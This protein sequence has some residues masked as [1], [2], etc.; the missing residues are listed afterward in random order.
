[1]TQD[2][3]DDAHRHVLAAHLG[4]EP[5]EDELATTVAGLRQRLQEARSADTFDVGEIGEAVVRWGHSPAGSCSWMQRGGCV[6]CRM[7]SGLAPVWRAALRAASRAGVRGARP[8][9]GR[10]PGVRP[11]RAR[12]PP[13][14]PPPGTHMVASPPGRRSLAHARAARATP[15]RGRGR[16]PD[17]PRVGGAHLRE[18]VELE[19]GVATTSPLRRE[20]QPRRL[21]FRAGDRLRGAC[22]APPATGRPSPPD[23]SRPLPDRDRESARHPV[24]RSA[25]DARPCR[26]RRRSCRG[27]GSGRSPLSDR[28]PELRRAQDGRSGHVPPF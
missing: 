25:R 9:G 26:G 3:A 2:E 11:S 17:D 13:E 16:A 20:S 1:M 21:R 28:T 24:R 8:L 23:T 14:S 18:Q 22:G 6:R 19:P 15:R 4:R 12:H 5:T 7:R 10:P 27:G